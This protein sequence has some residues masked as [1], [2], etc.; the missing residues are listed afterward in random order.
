MPSPTG[1]ERP[2]YTLDLEISTLPK[3]PNQLLHGHW[4]TVSRESRMWHDLVGWSVVAAR[5]PEAPLARARVWFTRRSRSEPDPD[6][7]VGSFKYVLD[8]LVS[9]RVLENDRRENVEPIYNWLRAQQGSIRIQ[10]QAVD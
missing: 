2:S 5:R 3:L 1:N 9:S 4:S 7:L 6:G 10:V 8:A